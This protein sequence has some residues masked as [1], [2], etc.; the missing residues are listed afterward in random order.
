MTE[1]QASSEDKQSKLKDK[2]KDMGV[3]QDENATPANKSKP[4]WRGKLPILIVVIFAIGFIWWI[5]TNDLTSSEKVAKSTAT[6]PTDSPAMGPG[7]PPQMRMSPPPTPQASMQE[8]QYNNGN[9]TNNKS[10]QRTDW[11]GSAN[12]YRDRYGPPPGWRPYRSYPPVPPP[13]PRYYGYPYYYGPP[14]V[15]Y[16]N[17]YY[18]GYNA[19]L[20]PPPK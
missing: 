20:P 8:P 13:P 16:P 1:E 2:L 17:P 6:N 5:S 12:R 18:R 11:P 3:M 4:F 14:P 15:F 10:D 19:P 9:I 7:Y